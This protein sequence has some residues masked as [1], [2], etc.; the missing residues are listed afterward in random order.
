MLRPRF[1][2]R[3]GRSIVP[4]AVSYGLVALVGAGPGRADLITVRGRYLLEHADV[5][6]HDRLDTEELLARA[7]S[8]TP[9]GRARLVNVGKQAGAHPVPQ[10]EINRILIRE[11][12]AVRHLGHCGDPRPRPRAA[13]LRPH[14]RAG[15]GDGVV[16]QGAPRDAAVLGAIG[17]AF[18]VDVC[19]VETPH[20]RAYAFFPRATDE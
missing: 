4:E 13:Q 12:A 5:V 2:R 8:A 11:A 1:A 16:A 18:G 17:D 7:G 9:A 20:G 14:R 6:V 10:G 3:S 19:E 15:G